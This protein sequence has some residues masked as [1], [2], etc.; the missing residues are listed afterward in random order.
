V[1]GPRE[2]RRGNQVTIADANEVLG[3]EDAWALDLELPR[4]GEDD[5]DENLGSD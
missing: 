1:G 2:A 5:F 3:Q 4:E